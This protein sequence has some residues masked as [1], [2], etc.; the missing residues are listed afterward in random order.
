MPHRGITEH[1]F[2]SWSLRPQGWSFP[3]IGH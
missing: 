2:Q 1:D 3:L